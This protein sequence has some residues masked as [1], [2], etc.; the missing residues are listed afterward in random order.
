MPLT[1]TFASTPFSKDAITLG[2]LIPDKRYPDLNALI[3]YDIKKEDFTQV[4]DQN[5]EDYIR[6]G[7][8]SSFKAAL[9]KLFTAS[10]SL[11]S[12]EDIQFS[13]KYARKYM[14]R[15]PRDVLK[16]LCEDSEVQRWL[17]EGYENNDKTY[18]I[19]GFR[20]LWNAKLIDRS[21]NDRGIQAKAEIPVGAAAGIEA[22]S[23]GM[24]DVTAE[25]SH[26][27]DED[28]GQNYEA[29]G[30]RIYAICYQKVELKLDSGIFESAKPDKDIKWR[31]YSNTKSKGV[32][33]S[34]VATIDDELNE[35]E[36]E[37]V[38]QRLDVGDEEDV[39]EILSEEN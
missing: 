31:S 23:Q 27:H 24:M 26:S 4:V 28:R 10:L 2:S 34:M 5:F 35:S 13:S 32:E 29:T 20:T 9:T 6:L 8:H 7:S 3:K 16:I 36:D 15:S 21:F 11:S 30:E 39:F 12:T 22:V 25:V 1:F 33:V 17:E 38:S 19:I 18:Y 14:L 37:S